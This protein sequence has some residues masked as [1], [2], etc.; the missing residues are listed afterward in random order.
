MRLWEG[1]SGDVS[2]KGEKLMIQE[3]GKVFKKASK[4][5]WT[6]VSGLATNK[7]GDNHILT[8]RS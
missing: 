7:I 5:K 8:R 3:E 2:V 1:V 4:V 6:Q